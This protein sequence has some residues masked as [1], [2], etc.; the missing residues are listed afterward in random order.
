MPDLV[1]V[2]AFNVDFIATASRLSA[3]AEEK[4]GE[5]TSRFEWNA[6]GPV[7]EEVVLR[8]MENLGAHTLDSS[9][10][11]SAWNT[12]FSL[13]NMDAGLTLGYVGVLGRIEAPG[14]SFLRQMVDLGIDRRMVSVRPDLRAGICLS[15]IEDDVRVML[16]SPCANLE[17]A[18]YVDSRFDDLVAY[19]A[20]ARA[21][22]LTS[23][24]DS[25]TPDAVARLLEAVVA[26]NPDLLI[27]FDP[28]HEWAVRPTEAVLRI[29]ELTHVLFVNYKEFKALGSYSHGEADDE[30][31]RRVVRRCAP[32]ATV[33]VTKR[34]D[35]I[36]VFSGEAGGSS[37]DM[38]R[39]TYD[40][41]DPDR[42]IEDATG[43]GDV[44]AAAVISALLSQRLKLELGAHLG[45][46]LARLKIRYMAASGHFRFPDLARGYLQTRAQYAMPRPRRDAVLVAHDGG[47]TWEPLERFLVENCA[48]RVTRL[49]PTDPGAMP[50]SLS[51]RQLEESGF[52]ICVIAPEADSDRPASRADE[53]LVHFSGYLQGYFG[54]D[55]VALLVQ[56]GCHIFSN[57][58]GLLCLGFRPGSVQD[59]FVELERM[60]RREGMMQ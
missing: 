41:A 59:S 12:I 16:T 55:R 58:A 28:G 36:E 48:V 18:S 7:A 19:L 31:G 1:G 45:T 53:R 34:Y 32:G 43:A 56:D 37:A 9:L 39:Y 20:G 51:R 49:T 4:I 35:L 24:L 40:F 13:A 15:F 14:L 42:D 60:L 33:L 25:R 22:H 17:M 2:G 46:S 3:R 11:G 6:E 10:G 54:F 8:A 47:S 30:L 29:L 27:C 38:S 50:S 52:A 44:F 23:F 57:M 21:V 26:R 5:S